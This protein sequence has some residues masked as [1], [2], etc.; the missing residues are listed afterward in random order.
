M[1]LEEEGRQDYQ[2]ALYASCPTASYCVLWIGETNFSLTSFC[3]IPYAQLIPLNRQLQRPIVPQPCTGDT[4]SVHTRQQLLGLL[5]GEQ[6]RNNR[7]K[8]KGDT[9][10]ISKNTNTM[11]GSFCSSH[12]HS[13]TKNKK[14]KTEINIRGHLRQSFFLV[15]SPAPLKHPV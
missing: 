2:L 9:A 5:F 13:H 4:Q 12:I 10:I 14:R 15:K 3:S 6:L 1:R 7:H 11:R 8:V